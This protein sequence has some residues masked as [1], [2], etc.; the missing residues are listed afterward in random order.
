MEKARIR[1]AI[2]PG[3]FDP[4]TNGHLDIVDRALQ[5]FDSLI[6]AV[7]QNSSKSTL[8]TAPERSALINEVV[9]DRQNVTVE[10]FKGLLVDF[11]FKNKCCVIIR[12]IRAVSDFEYEFQMALM[13]RRLNQ[14]IETV[15]MT[16]QEEYSFLSSGLVKEVCALGG[17]LKGLVPDIVEKELIQRLAQTR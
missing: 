7:A 14:E 11:A 1:R 16:P 15:F 3:T 4:I 9:G 13:N 2:Y 10:I 6:V 12:G 17:S 8:F 5:V